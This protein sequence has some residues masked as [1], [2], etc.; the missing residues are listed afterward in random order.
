MFLF[1]Y[2]IINIIFSYCIIV[3]I[4]RFIMSKNKCNYHNCKNKLN[5]LNFTCKCEFK[6]CLKHRLPEEHDCSFSHKNEELYILKTKLF[7]ERTEIDKITNK[8]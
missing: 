3:S 8:L 4:H 1:L 6:F 5:M 7:N 2:Y